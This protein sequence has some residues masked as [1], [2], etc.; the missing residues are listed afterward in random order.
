MD[1][2]RLIEYILLCFIVTC[3]Y[4]LS[5]NNQQIMDFV[6]NTHNYTENNIT[7]IT[8]DSEGHTFLLVNSILFCFFQTCE[9]F[10]S[11][12]PPIFTMEF[13]TILPFVIVGAALLSEYLAFVF[14]YTNIPVQRLELK[15]Q[16][17]GFACLIF[18]LTIVTYRSYKKIQSRKITT[19]IGIDEEPHNNDNHTIVLA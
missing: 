11:Y 8:V 19:P 18:L 13:S 7:V 12:R 16:L 15:L 5:Y 6:H 17:T 4:L 9:A 1:R 3:F 2:T 14:K 10:A